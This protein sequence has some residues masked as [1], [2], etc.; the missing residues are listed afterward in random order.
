MLKITEDP[1]LWGLRSLLQVT[2]PHCIFRAEQ[3]AG[4][5]CG[6]GKNGQQTTKSAL[7]EPGTSAHQCSHLL[8]VR[9]PVK[10]NRLPQRVLVLKHCLPFTSQQEV[11]SFHFCSFCSPARFLPASLLALGLPLPCGP[12]SLSKHKL[13]CVNPA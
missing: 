10:G 7:P 12:N 1:V 9:E 4:A 5:S 3:P 13:N 11:V 2:E 6:C 8:R